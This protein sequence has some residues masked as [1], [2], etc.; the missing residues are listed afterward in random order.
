[1]IA[2]QRGQDRLSGNKLN[3]NM[4]R[5]RL[6]IGDS[7]IRCAILDVGTDIGRGAEPDM[8][9]H[10]RL[11]L[12]KRR[13]G[14]AKAAQSETGLVRNPYQA[15]RFSGKCAQFRQRLFQAD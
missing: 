7:N 15:M 13:D 12:P 9:M 14:I 1:M 10:R 3:G 8:E 6:A 4:G 2:A 11:L 5:W